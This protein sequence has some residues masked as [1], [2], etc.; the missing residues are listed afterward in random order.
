MR[1]GESQADGKPSVR[2]VFE[3]HLGTVPLGNGLHQ[4]QSE[5]TA[6]ALEVELLER[7]QQT[8]TVRG[9]NPGAVIHHAQPGVFKGDSR[10]QPELAAPILH[11]VFQQITHCQ[12]Q[13]Q[14]VAQYR[15][16][17]KVTAQQGSSVS[18]LQ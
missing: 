9:W 15:R 16:T 1:S 18:L 2:R 7:P 10:A 14:R 8:G 3:K 4:G 12:L 5:T 6:A 17:L 13:G 11:G